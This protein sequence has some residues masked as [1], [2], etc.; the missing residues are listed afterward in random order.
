[1]NYRRAFIPNGFIFLTLVTNDRCPIL[2][3]NISLLKLAYKNVKIY[4]SFELISYS[5][6]PDHIHCIIYPCNVNDYPKIVKSFKYS[7]TK[8]YKSTCVNA[9]S[10][11]IWQNRYWEHTIRDEKD[12]NNHYNYIHYNPVKHG[13]V[14]AVKEWEYSSFYQFVNQGLC[15]ENWGNNNDIK[16]VINMNFE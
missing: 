3:P 14:N 11:R 4:Y 7:F 6:L 16:D 2:T 13:L 15:E 12:L 5:I 10:D 9:I 1:M 8:L